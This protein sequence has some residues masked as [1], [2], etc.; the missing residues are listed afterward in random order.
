MSPEVTGVVG[1]LVLLVLLAVR[2]PIALSMATVGLGGFTYLV[3]WEPALAILESAPTDVLTN[4]GFSAIPLFIFMGVLASKAR[5][6]GELFDMA[7]TVFGAWRGGMAMAA[8]M[9]SG[10]FS[11]IS[12]SSLATAA[13]ISKVALPEMEKKGYAQSLASG[14]LAAGGTLGVIIPPSIALLLYGLITEQS[15]GALFIAALVP[16]LLGVV[17][18]ALAV[19]LVVTLKPQ[20]AGEPMPATT[21]GEKVRSL[22]SVGPFLIIFL[23][24][25][26]GLYTGFFTPTEAAAV[27]TFATL[28]VAVMRGVGLHDIVS[29]VGE[30]LAMAV[31][32]FFMLLGAEI[33][34]YFLSV[35]RLSFYISDLISGAGMAPIG[36]LLCILLLYLV[37]GCFMDSMAMMLL[38]V[39]VVFPAVMAAGFDPIWFGVITVITVEIGLITPPVGMNVFVIKAA[40]RH[41]PLSAI[42]R[43][44]TPFIVAD[45]FRLALLVAFPWL[46]IGVLVG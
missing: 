37:L 40:A 32:I 35:S 5:M 31:V 13:T 43:G 6:A 41:V 33:F 1:I 22:R 24:V 3:G 11:A 10:T 12:G 44:V 20:L 30:S 9:A 38:T 7:R 26:G 28:V 17:C 18:Y 16:G 45:L 36:V 29:A 23:I 4:F 34:G 19:W 39:P 25:L 14:V 8:V 27:G 46:M 42:F 15:V 2:M 21:F